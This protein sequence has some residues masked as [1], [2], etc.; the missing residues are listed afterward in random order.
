M[1]WVCPWGSL[2]SRLAGGLRW[3]W[4]EGRGWCYY[5]LSGGIVWPLAPG[6]RWRVAEVDGNS[7]GL[8]CGPPKCR[9][10]AGGVKAIG[11][12]AGGGG[13]SSLAG[14]CNPTAGTQY[15]YTL[16][17]AAC[18]RKL[19]E[20]KTQTAKSGN[21]RSRGLRQLAGSEAGARSSTGRVRRARTIPLC[22]WKVV[23]AGRGKVWNST[24]GPPALALAVSKFCSCPTGSPRVRALIQR[25][26]RRAPPSGA[27]RADDTRGRSTTA[28]E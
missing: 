9:R 20:Q 23:W 21:G 7:S 2:S 5:V 11:E 27:V 10:Q 24:F 18:V 8:L 25:C 17:A 15:K 22:G 19:R 26:G 3:P 28:V 14:V 16:T 13:G 1:S 4:R 6:W 12:A